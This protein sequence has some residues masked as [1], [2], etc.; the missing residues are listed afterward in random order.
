MNRR[1]FTALT[2]LLVLGVAALPAFTS[3]KE[4]ALKVGFVNVERVIDE[5]KKTKDIWSQLEKEDEALREVFRQ[6][7]AAWRMERA[8]LRNLDPGTLEYARQA[9]DLQLAK[10]KLEADRNARVLEVRTRLK[11][12]LQQVYREVLQI[13]EGIARQRGMVAVFQV[14]DPD[15]ISDLKDN[16]LANILVRSTVWH[17]QEA[18]ITNEVIDL[19]NR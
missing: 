8:N 3:E 19:L 12:H 15:Q 18:D 11:E 2:L 16:V 17:R 1:F 10:T 9:R 14:S 7:L 4:P 13:V 5:Y 6:K